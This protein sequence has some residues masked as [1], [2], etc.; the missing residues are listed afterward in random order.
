VGYRQ[1]WDHCDGKLSLE[2]AVE[3]GVI[4]TRQLAKR[5]MTWL[6]GWQEEIDWFDSLDPNR[7]D[8][9]LKRLERITI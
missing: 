6:R 1:L 4:A 3:R 2:A 8:L 5:Q 7:F 9:A